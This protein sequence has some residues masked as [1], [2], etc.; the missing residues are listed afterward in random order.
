M[1]RYTD[2]MGLLCAIVVT[3]IKSFITDQHIIYAGAE[4]F[5]YFSL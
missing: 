4:D 1:W 5:M 2:E 3:H